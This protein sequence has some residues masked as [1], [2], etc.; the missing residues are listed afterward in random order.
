MPTPT[1]HPDK[2]DHPAMPGKVYVGTS[3]WSYK[4]WD[5]TFYP[6][7]V[8]RN[9][10]LEYYTTQFPS[11]EINATFYRLPSEQMVQGWRN[12]VSDRFV[13]AV[14]GS[15]FI[16]HMKKLAGLRSEHVRN[17]FD[18]LQPLQPLTAVVLWQL[19]GMLHKDA[20]RLRS[21]LR[22]L[23]VNY[24]HAVEFRH[25][26]WLDDEIFELLREHRAA[27]VS[28]SSQAM[29]MNLT[30]T[31]DLVYVRFH[32]L[33][34]GAA[35]DYTDAELKPWIQFA[36]SEAKRK[37]TVLLY[38]NNDVNTRAPE[39]A[40]RVMQMLGKYAVLPQERRPPRSGQQ[41]QSAM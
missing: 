18:R 1:F 27:Y 2:A 20:R 7:E 13:Y 37:R 23:P 3:G 12:K 35:H 30:V 28:V 4:A 15:R 36:R 31:T 17:L 19:P 10:Q 29:P 38:F 5:K 34:D 11:V 8:P 16:T 21:F 6:R 14:K 40:R 9:R 24:R 25:S 26:S 32:G 41:Q 22:R 33:R 39:N